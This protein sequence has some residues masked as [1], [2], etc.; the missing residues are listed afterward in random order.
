[1]SKVPTS[2]LPFRDTV[3]CP[4]HRTKVGLP[5]QCLVEVELSY[6]LRGSRYRL[7]RNNSR[8]GRTLTPPP[9]NENVHSL[10]QIN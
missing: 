9:Q 4:S 5:E 3:R 2:R 6:C 8:S 10:E 1:M 7:R